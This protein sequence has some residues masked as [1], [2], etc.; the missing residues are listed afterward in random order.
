MPQR[1]FASR[2][3]AILGILAL[4]GLC[5]FAQAPGP[6]AQQGMTPFAAFQQG[7]IDSINL[8][9]GNV[10]VHIPLVSYPQRGGKLRLA[11]NF[12]DTNKNWY[13]STTG[14]S[15]HWTLWH[16]P[17]TTAPTGAW[18]APDQG[19][20][21]QFTTA[22]WTDDAGTKFVIKLNN[23]ITSD[24]ASHEILTVDP[25]FPNPGYSSDG[26]G[27]YFN[28][29]TTSPIFLDNQGN[30]YTAST[31]LN[32]PGNVIDSNG[33]EVTYGANGW[34]DTIGRVV[35]GY[36]TSGTM[37]TAPGVSAATTHCPSGTVSA[38]Q[39][40]VP[41]P[42]GSTAPYIFCYSNFNA[43]TAFGLPNVKEASGT[44]LMISAIVLPNLTKWVFTYDSY[45]SIASVTMPTGGS[46]SYTWATDAFVTGRI[47]ASRTVNANDGTG[48]HIWNYTYQT[49][50]TSLII[51]DPLLNESVAS[52]IGGR[53]TQMQN[54]SGSHT[55]GTL[56][57]TVVTAY[58]PLMTGDPMGN[59]V[60]STGTINVIPISSTT[61]WAASGK[62]VQTTT[63]YDPG[64]KYGIF[65]SD[66]T[67]SYYYANYGVPV[68]QTVSDYGSGSPGGIL[69]QTAT[70]YYWQS[71]SNYLTA[72][73]L[74]LPQSIKVEDANSK[75]CAETDY[76]YDNASYLTA[77]GISTQHSSPPE[78]VRGNVS[79]ITH[80]LASS[81][82]PCVANPSW[83]SLISYVNAYDTGTTYKAID[84]L[85]HTT[86]YNYSATY[87]GAYPTTVSNAL[88]QSTINTYDFNSGKL[89]S[90]QDPNLL[91]TSYSYDSMARL[92]QVS[93][94]DGGQTTISRQETTFPFSATETKKIN[95]TINLVTTDI[96]DGLGR[97]YRHEL[98]SDPQGTI[99]TDKTYDAIGRVS[100]VTNPYRS[101]TDITTSSGT[102]T[103]GYD[104]LSRKITETYPDGS[105]LTTAYCL[106]S[107]LVTDPAGKWRR[108][109]IDGLGRMVEVDEPNAIGA[110][111]ATS[112]CPGTGEPIWVTSYGYD[113]LGN[114]ISVLQNG[115]HAR[116]FF[117][118]TL[119]RMTSSTNP[120]VGTITYA[121]NNDSV[122]VSKTD[123]R[124]ITTNYSPAASP[125]DALHRV[126]EITYSNSDPTIAYAYDQ[127]ACL[128]LTACQNIGHR[129]SM[130]DAAGSESYAY[131]VDKT[132]S[133]SI[134]VDQRTTSSITKTS[135]YYLDL[136]GNVT[137][138]IYPTGRVVNYTY[139]A[140][141]RAS[142]AIDG[143]N[144]ITY[145]TGF[146]SSPGGTCLVNV[147]C[148]TPQGSVYAVSIGQTSSFTGLNIT[149]TFN[150]R[151]QPN[152]FK[153]SS[154]GGNAIDITYNF[155][156]PGTLKNAGHVN[157]I[158]NNLNSS[159]T[160]TF[161]Y[162]QLNRITSAGTS[163]TTGTLCWGYQY[164]YDGIA[165]S[166]GAWGNL[167]SQAGWTPT[168][169]A[170]TETVMAA[171]TTDGN[172]H[173]S[174]FGYDTSGNATSDGVYT[175]TWNGE[176]QLKSGGGVT[177]SYDGDGRRAAKSNGKLYWYGA[178]S[179]VLAETNAS[180]ATLNEYVYF[181]GKRVA[182]LPS[183]ST[184]QYYVEDQ[185]GSSRIVTT[186]TGVV[187]Y[188]A[189][190][191]PF[192]QERPVTNS[193][194]QN[195]YKFEGKE[196][197]AETGNDDF[198][199]RSYS[200]RYGR[201]LSADW[202]SAPVAVP[203]ANLSNPQTL[204]LY[205]MTADD[206][207]SFS[208]LDGHDLR[209]LPS[210]VIMNETEERASLYGGPNLVD[211]AARDVHELAQIKT[212]LNLNGTNVDVTYNAAEFSNGQKGAVIDANPQ[213][214]CGNCRWAQT[215]TRTGDPTQP[216]HT[217]RESDAASGTQ[218]LYPGGVHKGND[219]ANFHD[220]PKSNNAG[221]FT[222]VT[223]LGVADK[224][225]KSF[226]VTGSMAWGYK[227][228]KNGNVSGVAPRVATKAEQAASIAVLR[229][230]SPTWTIGP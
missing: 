50:Q 177:Y 159:R 39:W 91:T 73:L 163:A 183:G 98:T 101:G 142:T 42:N 123:A 20:K 111:V 191:P 93:E 59:Y 18:V 45:L 7:D 44:Y 210:T 23:A 228:D 46:I 153:A 220:E 115:S 182:L 170:C 201:W 128:G 226:K 148:Y 229:R 198:G 113:N 214:A 110:T 130:T 26:T 31:T 158:V 156:D 86:T 157:S 14:G 121:Y 76:T 176:S 172:N 145:A 28:G 96:V 137:Q 90:T 151:L 164:T 97:E 16:P 212:T 92:T 230:E 185:L 223:T 38:L 48:N 167:T 109:R 131:E 53:V 134:H 224:S 99:Y 165:S 199:A 215:V 47:I 36:P 8:G 139:D 82:T 27:I 52:I 149:D 34:T 126:T 138:A 195:V 15:A 175:Y 41:A 133:R 160:Q 179:E 100:T 102:T 87:A 95:T 143:S 1:T 12:Y 33:N 30:E 6:D 197:D 196:R 40:N 188:D 10:F 207:E 204:N 79:S 189:D 60:S 203:Y 22:N 37:T 70:G 206:P 114:L 55:S 221:T 56:L 150:T 108:S 103:Y 49:Y 2:Y 17:N 141:G 84:P 125:I 219:A 67:T 51:A 190:F 58:S 65:N 154:T 194:L 88:S 71:Y 168:Y 25:R 227:I 117:Y 162:D 75:V 72:N 63:T 5:A 174:A 78:S 74:S 43:Q 216:T 83:T 184:A 77:S 107:T 144:G 135:T 178:G 29:N 225:N 19:I 166:G 140:A 152:E 129:T 132:N 147:T 222:A 211:P 173:I 89:A 208:D 209:G 217:D 106:P 54:Y 3:L 127:A 4:C 193:C 32:G 180:G 64:F 62:T 85:S 35:P 200:N 146:K 213:G 116:S 136:A 21:L 81:S 24:G 119:S 94:P 192:G 181:G 120:E 186:N 155:V 9:T 161:T 205:S 112:G 68:N 118:D 124:A 66:G 169:S 104:A 171:V 80:Q 202:S 13:V 105:I 11:F 122:L 187:C 57:E 69:K 218:P 61:T